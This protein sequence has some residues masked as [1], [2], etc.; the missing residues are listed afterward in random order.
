MVY[1]LTNISGGP[2]LVEQRSF[3]PSFPRSISGGIFQKHWK[4]HSRVGLDW[5]RFAWITPHLYM[6]D[7]ICIIHHNCRM[8]GTYLITYIYMYIYTDI[9]VYIFIHIYIY[10]YLY[11][12]LLICTF[13]IDRSLASGPGA[14]ASDADFARAEPR[15]G[16]E[17][18]RGDP[19][20]PQQCTT[21]PAE[22][23]IR[24]R[25]G[26]DFSWCWWD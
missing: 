2:H 7:T 20:A 16:G 6:I 4:L 18:Q 17:P 22:K 12:Y 15:A 23:K 10:L 1:K 3:F 11:L 14:H 13:S 5:L 26:M 25:N 9:F 21:S 24:S 19:G 8:I